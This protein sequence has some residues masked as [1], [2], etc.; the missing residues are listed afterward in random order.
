[1][2]K[3]NIFWGLFLIASAVLILVAKLG[4]F[5]DMSVMKIFWTLVFTVALVD[6]VVKPVPENKEITLSELALDTDGAAF[7]EVGNYTESKGFVPFGTVKITADKIVY[8]GEDD[9][10]AVKENTASNEYDINFRTY[11]DEKGMWISVNSKEI[12]QLPYAYTADKN[13]LNAYK[14]S[15]VDGT[16]TMLLL[17]PIFVPVVQAMGMDMMAFSIVFMIAIMSGGMTPPV[18]SMLFIISALENI[19]I[20]KMAKPVFVYV[21]ALL[22]VLLLIMAFPVIASFLP[23]LVYG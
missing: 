14:V 13:I 20:S 1:M 23:S 22:V 5:P 8:C 21:G 19:S 2:K 11:T 3:D 4:A 18:G 17:T 6:S 9:V 7:V 16:A 15:F 10:V 12:S